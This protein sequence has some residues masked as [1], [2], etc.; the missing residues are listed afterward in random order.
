MVRTAQDSVHLVA[1]T[2]WGTVLRS[3]WATS[4]LRHQTVHS[5]H[6][7]LILLG[8]ILGVAHALTQ[9]AAPG[10]KVRPV[11]AVVPFVDRPDP[12]GVGLG[13]LAIELMLASAASVLV[14][15]KLGFQR[16]R[17]LHSLG[18]AAFTM[19]AAHLLISGTE[20]SAAP[21][22]AAIAASWLVVLVAG[23]STVASVARLP[24]AVLNRLARRH[25]AEEITIAVDPGKCGQFGFCEQE[26]PSI[27]TLRSDQRLAYR[28]VVPAD[29]ADVAMRAAMVC[30]ARAIKLGRLPATVVVSQPAPDQDEL[31]TPLATALSERKNGADAV[32]AGRSPGV[33]PHTGPLPAHTTGS[34]PP[35][36]DP[37][38]RTGSMPPVREP[39]PPY[40]TGSMPPVR[41]PG[42]PAHQPAY[43][44]GSMPPVREPG[45]RSGS[46]PPVPGAG[47]HTGSMPPVPENGQ[48]AGSM[49]PVPEP[50]PTRDPGLRPVDGAGR[51][52]TRRAGFRQSTVPV[53][54]R[55]SAHP[56][57]D[58]L[59]PP[60]DLRDTGRHHL[61]PLRGI[62]GGRS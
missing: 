31:P 38:Y 46:T 5:T 21:I 49:P 15:R 39:D 13:V 44:A 40:R 52:S 32:P 29:Q 37:G 18:Y 28:S 45:Y 1:A 62:A 34:I 57:D 10:G 58:A 19:V 60:S 42:H 23:I 3:G 26:A 55:A 16:W 2:I 43:Q 41:E 25:R 51:R 27:F 47:Y 12:I 22:R 7:H 14:Q 59:P 4:R 20:V 8:L 30:P 9:L 61:P 33:S 50:A 11:D 6:M 35:V 56:P 53:G 48:H 17:A 36:R 24:R 54:R